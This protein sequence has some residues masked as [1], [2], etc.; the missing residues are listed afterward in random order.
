MNRLEF[1]A[2]WAA[3]LTALVAAGAYSWYQIQIDQKRR[4]LEAYLKSEKEKDSDLR[5]QGQHNIVHLMAVL[6][7]TADEIL[8]A[9]FRS[10]KII[11]VPIQDPGVKRAV[12]IF[13]KYQDSS[14]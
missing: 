8:Q 3:I 10:K 5:R 6:G 4:K 13:F 12:D 1:F 7:F 9:S 14:N 11:R 2:N